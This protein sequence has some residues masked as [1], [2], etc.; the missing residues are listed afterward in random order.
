LAAFQGPD[1]GHLDNWWA[2]AFGP[3]DWRTSTEH[4][5]PPPTLKVGD[6]IALG[7]DLSADIL[8][9]REDRLLRLRLQ[10]LDL[11]KSIYQN[12]R[13]IQYSYLI[14]DLHVWDQQTL[15]AQTPISVEPPSAALRLHWETILR[16]KSQ[17]VQI[18]SVLHGA[19]IS[20]TG[21]LYIDNLL[22][23]P[24]YFEVPAVTADAITSALA[25][26]HQVIALGTTVLR[27]LES[28]L[29][30]GKVSARSGMTSLKITPGHRVRSVTSLIT[31]MHERESSHM[32]ILNSLCSA[33]VLDRGYKEATDLGYS[34]H[35]YGDLT[36]VSVR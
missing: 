34:S 28:S 24:E 31:G 21:S 33:D 20:S 6:Q 32:Q 2:V 23:L 26:K 15:F 12:A 14:E 9:V 19:G 29:R 17:R 30:F 10:S 1:L 16:L 27:A 4:R 22:P 3:G 8:E 35:E 25:A 11:L 13:P 36:M 5:A 7:S 18:V